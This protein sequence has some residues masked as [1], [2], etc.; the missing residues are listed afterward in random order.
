[1]QNQ[2]SQ[3]FAKFMH[4]KIKKTKSDTTIYTFNRNHC[5]SSSFKSGFQEAF[6]VNVI[7]NKKYTKCT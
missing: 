2:I 5:F 1:M 6:L 4:G 7:Y 3:S